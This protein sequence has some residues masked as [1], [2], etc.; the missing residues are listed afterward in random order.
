MREATK[1]HADLFKPNAGISLDLQ[2]RTALGKSKYVALEDPEE[3]QQALNNYQHAASEHLQTLDDFIGNTTKLKRVIDSGSLD[4]SVSRLKQYYDAYL[5]GDIIQASLVGFES[6]FNPYFEDI[7]LDARNINWMRKGGIQAHC[8]DGNQCLVYAGFSH[9]LQGKNPLFKLLQQEGFAIK[10][11]TAAQRDELVAAS[12]G[13]TTY[14]HVE[15]EL[16]GE[17]DNSQ[18]LLELGQQEAAELSPSQRNEAL[19]EAIR[20]ENVAALEV[21]VA[22]LAADDVD[23]F[24]NKAANIAALL[25]KKQ[26]LKFFVSKG[27][28][29]FNSYLTSAAYGGNL[30]TVKYLINQG[31]DNISGALTN[32]MIRDHTRLV[33]FFI[34]ELAQ[35]ESPA[36]LRRILNNL[37]PL[38]TDNDDMETLKFLVNAGADDFNNLLVHAAS[39]GNAKVIALAIK[40][41]ADNL[42]EA[43]LQA[44]YGDHSSTAKYLFD[45]LHQNSREANDVY[46]QAF[47]YAVSQENIALAKFMINGNAISLDT[48]TILAV[49]AKYEGLIEFLVQ[50]GIDA[51]SSWST[52]T[53]ALEHAAANGWTKI[54]KTILSALQHNPRESLLLSASHDHEEIVKFILQIGVDAESI[55]TARELAVVYGNDS[56]QQLLNAKL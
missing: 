50:K 4:D 44:V 22:S 34:S 3:L 31:A 14:E 46:S 53:W 36:I 41:G 56:I 19:L 52:S 47:S 6:A 32:A 17:Q 13:T 49:S 48:A 9:F 43:F 20:Q 29:D 45:L 12:S 25:G 15:T 39:V 1:D 37:L 23:Q 55:R 10:E 30:A 38:Y 28:N 16:N 8:I 2:I 35:H 26:T 7:L 54:V 21:L 51:P 18:R 11:L 40:H 5:K 24:I 27:A 33:K 42:A